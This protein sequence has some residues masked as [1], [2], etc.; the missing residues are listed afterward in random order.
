M[1]TLNAR[2][3]L[4]VGPGTPTTIDGESGTAYTWIPGDAPWTK[5]DFVLDGRQQLRKA[6]VTQT[7]DNIVLGSFW[8]R[9]APEAR[10]D[11]PT[12]QPI[13]ASP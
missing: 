2:D 4:P 11:D 8:A 7:T 6:V 5:V 9:P 3:R 10:I 12:G 13:V 1:I